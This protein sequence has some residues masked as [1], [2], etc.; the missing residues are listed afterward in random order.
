MTPAPCVCGGEPRIYV[1][2]NTSDF[3]HVYCP[4]CG[5]H[6]QNYGR[7]RAFADWN[8]DMERNAGMDRDH[9]RTYVRICNDR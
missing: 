1:S 4:E 2:I 6:H 7:D 3:W 5:A 8:A 9:W